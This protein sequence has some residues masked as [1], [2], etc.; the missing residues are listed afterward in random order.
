MNSQ[1][2]TNGHTSTP[3]PEPKITA[4]GI[5]AFQAR[6]DEGL[7]TTA[8]NLSRGTKVKPCHANQMVNNMLVKCGHTAVFQAAHIDECESCGRKQTVPEIKLCVPH[9]IAHWGQ[10]EKVVAQLNIFDDDGADGH[11]LGDGGEE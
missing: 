7:F 6:F 10:D 1:L 4:A 11:E 5:R 9:A 2:T 8:T 3:I